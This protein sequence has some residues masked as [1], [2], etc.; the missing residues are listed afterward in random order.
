MVAPR[1]R[2]LD[3]LLVGSFHIAPENFSIL[4]VGCIGL[5]GAVLMLGTI[6][7]VE[8]MIFTGPA[9]VHVL[10]FARSGPDA[11]KLDSF[12]DLVSTNISNASGK[13]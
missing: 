9:G 1:C 7:K 4:L 3:T 13:A 6:R 5:G 10:D 8:F 12:V 11:R 2:F